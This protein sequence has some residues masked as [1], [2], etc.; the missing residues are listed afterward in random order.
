MEST[1]LTIAVMTYFYT[2]AAPQPG[3]KRAAG[4]IIGLLLLLL[5]LIAVGYSI[6][7]ILKGGNA[8]KTSHRIEKERRRKERL[9]REK[10]E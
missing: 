9:E 3:L 6:F 10:A 1:Y 7:F 8:L 2:D 4:W 5:P